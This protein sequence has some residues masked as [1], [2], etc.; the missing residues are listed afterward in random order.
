MPESFCWMARES[1]GGFMTEASRPPKAK[2]STP[3]SGLLALQPRGINPNKRF[4]PVGLVLMIGVWATSAGWAQESVAENPALAG[5][6]PRSA[7]GDAL[8][9]IA[10]EPSPGAPLG[11]AQHFLRPGAAALVYQF[12][13]P[14][15][16][17]KERSPLG[18]HL[19]S[20]TIRSDDFEPR[21][22]V[23]A[24]P[25]SWEG[26][27]WQMERTTQGEPLAESSPAS[28]LRQ[29][30]EPASPGGVASASAALF[31][32][33]YLLLIAPAAADSGGEFD[34]DAETAPAL[35]REP[36]IE[37][38][39]R[40]NQGESR[41]WALAGDAHVWRVATAEAAPDA[42]GSLSWRGLE[43]AANSVAWVALP[44]SGAQAGFVVQGAGVLEMAAARGGDFRLQTSLLRTAPSEIV[45]L[46][47]LDV[48][49]KP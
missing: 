35:L 19:F 43:S 25:K 23:Y 10:A 24:L 18:T 26:T 21:A 17:Q 47:L 36:E 44:P 8:Q 4:R 39:P 40:L 11:E 42:E 13:L 48:A 22:A 12:S 6:A 29:T 38:K 41:R 2:N 32:G 46:T 31:S 33:D 5:Q 16:G 37:E 28:W 1:S 15:K 7:T 30:D 14:P 45:E 3:L 20:A 27:I 9:P 34:L 49:V